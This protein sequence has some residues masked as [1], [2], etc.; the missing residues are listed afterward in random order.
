MV[1]LQNIKKSFIDAN[2]KLEVLKDVNLDIHQGEFVYITGASGCGKSTLLHLIGLLD[3]PSSGSLSILNKGVSSI[4]SVERFRNINMGFV[5]QSHFLLED[6]TALENIMIP[7]LIQNVSKKEA[8][9]RALNMLKIIGLEDRKNHLPRKLSGGEEQRIAIAR[10]IVTNP[11]ILIADEPTGNL[12][13]ENSLLVMDLIRKLNSEG[14]TVV[15][16]TH[17]L[18]LPR[19]VDSHYTLIDGKLNKYEKKK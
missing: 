5:F 15:L 8:K 1:K 9:E 3:K 12:D 13:Q 16:V 7:L 14:L 17:D 11:K 19:E 18:S 10:A 4:K 6:F 2:K